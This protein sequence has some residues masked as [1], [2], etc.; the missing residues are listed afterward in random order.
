M[1]TMM[2]NIKE[3][4]LRYAIEH[5]QATGVG[6]HKK[7]NKIHKKLQDLYNETKSHKILNV[8]TEFLN[9]NNESVRLWAATFSL[10]NN[11]EIAVEALEKLAEIT[12]ITG[13]SAKTTLH[14]WKEGKLN[15]L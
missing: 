12:S 5:G 10:N 14:L 2:E 13:L 1:D 4:F 9:N 3:T 11:P 15:L 6:D 7:A 8:F